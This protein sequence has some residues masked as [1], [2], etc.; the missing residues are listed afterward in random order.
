M[1]MSKSTELKESKLKR[2]LS[3][4]SELNEFFG[5]IKEVNLDTRIVRKHIFAST[6]HK[7]VISSSS[8]SSSG[9]Q[10]FSSKSLE[11]NCKE[12]ESFGNK[13]DR[14]YLQFICSSNSKHSKEITI[15]VLLYPNSTNSKWDALGQVNMKL[16]GS[17]AGN[18]DIIDS[19][20][21]SIYQ[22]ASLSK[23][24]KSDVA[25]ING[26]CS[27][28][29]FK[30]DLDVLNREKIKAGK[31]MLHVDSGPVQHNESSEQDKWII[32]K[33]HSEIIFPEEKECF[34]KNKHKVYLL[35]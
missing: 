25:K 14:I 30:I 33:Y 8:D 24:S 9:S 12:F 17:E 31:V 29:N 6:T 19:Y 10:L 16:S 23:L 2:K 20:G 27:G 1:E 28:K 3:E 26:N 35:R 7:T 32:D 5:N 18:I 22:I 15:D 34:H 11:R 4:S 21:Q 13:K